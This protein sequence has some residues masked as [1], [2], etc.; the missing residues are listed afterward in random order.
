MAEIVLQGSEQALMRDMGVNDADIERRKRYVGFLPEDLARIQALK[1]VVRRHVEEFTTAFFNHLMAFD[2]AR[3]LL[4]NRD[5]VDRVRRLK[6]DHL[7]AMVEGDY[8]I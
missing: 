4:A 8:G 3:P 2:E 6:H 7:L 5:A 1:D